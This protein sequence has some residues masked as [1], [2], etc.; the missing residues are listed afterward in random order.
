MKKRAY[1]INNIEE[2]GKFIAFCID[3]D[4]NVFRAYWNEKEKGKVCYEIDWKQKRCFY[5]NVNYFR[6]EEDY[7]II[8]PVFLADEFGKVFIYKGE[9]K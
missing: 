1:I 6:N 4:I 5:A 2:Y 9:N 8:E 7:E 3:K